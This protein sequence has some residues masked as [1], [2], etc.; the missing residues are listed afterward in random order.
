MKKTGLC[1]MLLL[2]VFTL[3]AQINP[4]PPE[5]FLNIKIP[6]PPSDG[7]VCNS[8]AEQKTEFGE[9]VSRIIK[10]AEDQIAY[11]RRDEK[12]NVVTMQE[13]AKQ[14]MQNDY[15]L[16][17]ADMQKL[18]SGKMSKEEKK[19]MADKVLKQQNAGL[20]VDKAK[21]VSKYSKEGKEAWAESYAAQQ[22]AEAAKDPKKNQQTLEN[23]KQYS[24]LLQE[25]DL[26]RRKLTAEEEKFGQ[27]LGE[28]ESDSTAI[29]LRRDIDALTT[30]Y[31]SLVGVEHGQGAEMEEIAGKIKS[32][33]LQYCNMLTPKYI[34]VLGLFRNAISK[35]MP[36]YYRM[37]VL[38][39]EVNKKTS[40]SAVNIMQKGLY[41]YNAIG[42]YLNI[43][44]DAYK[45]SIYDTD[46]PF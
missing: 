34:E 7:K 17:A 3:Q 42:G 24:D 44:H 18:Q 1:S 28:L 10:E 45:Y 2:M 6:S 29:Q 35:N 12:K 23:N 36:D 14:K 16:S 43:L 32:L 41:G 11:L 46:L 19:A 20:T 13:D 27:M 22:K 37:E 33:K 26:L 30:K 21:E 40:G 38:I 4:L 39:N 5:D 8:N 25:Q 15:G 31:M 9:S